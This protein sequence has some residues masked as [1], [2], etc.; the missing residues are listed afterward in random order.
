MMLISS[1]FF[2]PAVLLITALALSPAHAQEATPPGGTEIVPAAEV[3]AA[4]GAASDQPEA[5]FKST[6]APAAIDK[7]VA[8]AK[9]AA[10]PKKKPAKKAATD[11]KKKHSAKKKAKAPPPKDP[12]VSEPTED[13]QAIKNRA[14]QQFWDGQRSAPTAAE[15]VAVPGGGSLERASASQL[16]GVTFD[17][18]PLRMPESESFRRSIDTVAFEL[19]RPCRAREFLGWPLQ[20][21]EQTRVDRIFG[22]TIEKFRQRGF[23]VLPH[24]PKA[25]GAD[26][27]VFTADRTT[28]EFDRHI[29]GLWSAGDVGLLLMLCDTEAPPGTA[30]KA[31]PEKEKKAAPAKSKPKKPAAKPKKAAPKK[32]AEPKLE[33]EMEPKVEAIPP[34]PSAPPSASEGERPVVLPGVAP[35]EPPA[36]APAR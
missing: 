36:P 28:G 30:K 15:P 19:G 13:I 6:P 18:Q 29:L 24:Q 35:A 21:T 11:F 7:P 14:E 17:D 4:D 25:A 12:S 26:I 8:P 16:S 2:L 27:S 33:E 34:P 10:A 31:A 32:E 3:P 9:K 20:Q 1:R 23:T 5:A 22:E